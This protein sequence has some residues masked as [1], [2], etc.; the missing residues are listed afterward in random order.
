MNKLK[1]KYSLAF[2]FITVFFSIPSPSFACSCDYV[3]KFSEYTLGDKGIVRATVKEYG[4]KLPHGETLYESMTVE[5]TDVIKGKYNNKKLTLLGD[6]GHL[7]RDYVDSTRFKVGTEHLISI[8]SEKTTQPL[9]GCGESSVAIKDDQIVG[10]EWKDNKRNNY[11]MNL[12]EFVK[13]LT[14]Q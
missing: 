13:L 6:P 11:S 12:R 14:E 10:V 7:C 8:S 9:G 4:P 5:I 2:V 1:L 3:G